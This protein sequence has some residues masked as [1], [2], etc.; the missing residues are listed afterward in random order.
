[1]A[2]ELAKAYVQIVPSMRGTVPALKKELG[3]VAKSSGVSSVGKQI[4][5][6]LTSAI[7]KTLK[8][9]VVAAG[10]A[11]G[12]VLATSLSK[13]FGRLRAFEQ[14]EKSL[15]GMGLAADQV[16]TVMANANAAVDGTA[17]GLDAAATAARGLVAAGVEPGEQLERV[18]TLVGDSAA[19]AGTSMDE[20]GVIWQKVAAKGRLQGDEALQLM[21]RGIPIY[22]MVADQLGIT[23]EE[24]TKLGSQG[25]ISFDMFADAMESSFGGTA[26]RMGET[27]T[28]SFQNV[29]AAL[30]RLGQ[31]I[32]AGPFADLPGLFMSVRDRINAITP[33]VTEFSDKAYKGLKGVAEILSGASFSDNL[34]AV[35]GS[36]TSKVVGSLR[37]LRGGLD[38]VKGAVAGFSQAVQVEFGR[39]RTVR[40]DDWLAGFDR[41]GQFFTDTT[42]RL[43]GVGTALVPVVSHFAQAGAVLAG[44]VFSAVERLTP[45]FLDLA[46]AVVEA[47]TPVSAVLVPT[48]SAVV[49]LATPLVNLVGSLVEGM[50]RLPG[51]VLAAGAAFI[52]LKR[53]SEGITGAVTK[54]R[55]AWD[56][57]KLRKHLASM[58]MTAAGASGL[59]GAMTLAGTAVRGLGAAFKS[60]LV[61]NLPMLAI[62]GI[63]SAIAAFNS[64]SE[65]GKQQAESLANSFDE[66]GQ[67]TDDTKRQIVDMLADDDLPNRFE[68]VGISTKEVTDA[69]LEGGDA[70]ENLKSR[71]QDMREEALATGDYQL[72]NGELKNLQDALDKQ[73]KKVDEAKGK[74][75]LY[76][77]VIGSSAAEQ[78]KLED[79]IKGVIEADKARQ[80]QLAGVQNAALAA[81]AAERDYAQTVE[82]AMAK[83]ADSEATARDREAALDAIAKATRNTA[84]AAAEAGKPQEELNAIIARGEEDFR[85]AAEA[86]GMNAAEIDELWKTIGMAPDSVVT[87]V[88]V[89]TM[90]AWT[91]LADLKVGIDSTSGLVTIDGDP[92]LGHTKLRDLKGAIDN[93]DGT[94]TINGNR[95]PADQTLD[96]FLA[97]VVESHEYVT[98]DG[99]RV[100]ADGVLQDT[101][102][103]IRRGEESVTIDGKDYKARSV[104]N[105]LQAQVQRTHG[106]VNIGANPANFDS[107]VSRVRGKVVGTAYIQIGA[108]GSGVRML[109]Q[110]QGGVLEFYAHGGLK[111]KHVAQIAPAGAWRVW[112]EP[113]TGG[114]AYIPLAASKRARSTQILA[115]VADRFGYQLQR[116]ADGGLAGVSSSVSAGLPRSV[117]LQVGDREFTAYVSEV[118]DARMSVNPGV[119]AAN[120]LVANHARYRSQLGGF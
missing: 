10:V 41:V 33:A 72:A 118:A 45:A 115:E 105:Q 112:A 29:G 36:Q 43:V 74:W 77:D 66:L 46:S 42:A 28:G 26:L 91:G 109:Q 60:L 38:D 59:Q 51:P 21:E 75:G 102:A 110:A 64:T 94:V 96:E 99:D 6:R 90:A 7:G 65:K 120:D 9:G 32:L 16:A 13:G 73:S 100:K 8:T 49:A 27:V 4:G 76:N 98:I 2:V 3:G 53:H 97:S 70:V 23:A 108:T 52:M 54:M 12:G 86:A 11:T 79:A 5:G 87:R 37:R 15:E 101:L 113:E 56:T 117:V 111:E 48:A 55:G 84:E 116:Y 20:M 80:D 107:W 78:N 22:Q 39:L 58:E 92:M 62:T 71:L 30:G 47:G 24:A 31:G 67:A 89:D 104:L 93:E 35:F 40:L 103:A 61:A 1:M 17:F 68:K 19:Q 114:E 83:M 106:H 85:K 25:K 57:L 14:A 50:S 88:D 95:V 119:A 82:D 63:V 44:G 81:R 18:L 34:F 69:L